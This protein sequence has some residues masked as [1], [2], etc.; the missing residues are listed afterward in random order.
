MSAD[1]IVY[2]PSSADQARMA[3]AAFAVYGGNQGQMSIKNGQVYDTLR[4]QTVPGFAGG[5]EHQG[6]LRWVGENGPEL[7]YTPPSRIFSNSDSRNIIDLT[8]LVEEM[9][10]LRAEN[11]G[12]KTDLETALYAIAKYTQTSADILD[13]MDY[14]GMPAT[15]VA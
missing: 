9:R 8:P 6:G 4:G 5:G 2:N 13:K 1:G 14:V 12:L 3:A 10:A 7:E 15:R 11:K